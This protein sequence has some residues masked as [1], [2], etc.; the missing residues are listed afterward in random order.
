MKSSKS[1][2]IKKKTITAR[3]GTNY[4]KKNVGVQQRR[5]IGEARQIGPRK[6]MNLKETIMT[7]K[8]MNINKKALGVQGRS[9][10]EVCVK[11]LPLIVVRRRR[12]EEE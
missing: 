4:F 2:I 3:K 11:K 12:M 7:M 6:S 8:G 1:W 9:L 5:Q 10:A